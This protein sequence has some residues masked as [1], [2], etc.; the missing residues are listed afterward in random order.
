MASLSCDT[1]FSR[2]NKFNIQRLVVTE[3]LGVFR[4]KLANVLSSYL[5]TIVGSFIKIGEARCRTS[6]RG[7]NPIWNDPVGAGLLHLSGKMDCGL[8]EGAC[9]EMEAEMQHRLHCLTNM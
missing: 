2:G 3:L 7:V 9:E 4:N 6:R 5:S 1:R 8:E